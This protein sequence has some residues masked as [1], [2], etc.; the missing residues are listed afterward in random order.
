MNHGPYMSV[1]DTPTSASIKLGIPKNTL[2]DLER[3]GVV[4]PFMRDAANRRLLTEDDL[5]A[6]RTYLERRAK[7][8]GAA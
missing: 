2:V 8:G 7:Q 3:R 1:L 6:V 4:G 5:A